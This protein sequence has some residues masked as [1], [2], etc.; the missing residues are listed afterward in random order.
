MGSVVP[1]PRHAQY[2]RQLFLEINRL[3]S[4]AAQNGTEVDRRVVADLLA[5]AIGHADTR[6]P[7]LMALSDYLLCSLD[8]AVID[9]TTWQPP[10]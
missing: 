2:A 8:G 1:K 4:V 7:V 10:A 3:S 6:Q 9:L 5:D